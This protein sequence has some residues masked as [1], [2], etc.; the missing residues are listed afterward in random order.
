M[1]DQLSLRVKLL[2]GNG[3]IF[4]ILIVISMIVY[5]GINSLLNN[6]KWVDHTH[7]VLAKA[8]ATTAAA[9]D[10]ET[11]M[12]GFM[13]S[14][15]EEFLEPYKE[16]KQ[17]FYALTSELS[18]TV[19]DNPG[20]VAL[21]AEI[22]TLIT[23]WVNN[24]TEPNIAFRRTVG[25]AATME[26]VAELIRQAKGKAYFDSFR[27]KIAEFMSKEEVLLISRTDSFNSTS[28]FV[29]NVLLFGTL[30][31]I[32]IGI[33]FVS[34]LTKNIMKQLGGEPSFIAQIAKNVANGD[35]EICKSA[36]NSMQATGVLA[37]L[38]MMVT[39]LEKKSE[40]AN[41][42][43]Q[44]DLTIKVELA[45]DK[46]LLGISLQK[47][48]RNINDLLS[49][50]RSVST[51][52]SAGS[53]QLSAG[54]KQVAD[55]AN[56]QSTQ[57]ESISASLAQL[58]AQTNENAENA[59]K[60]QNLSLGAQGVAK[61]GTQNVGEMMTAMEDIGSSSQDIESFIKTI[62]EIAA[63]TNLLALNAAIEAA[64]AGEQGRG[65]AVVADEVRS[66]AARSA[67]TAQETSN[68]IAQSTEKT[69]NGIS[70]ATDTSE[71]LEDIFKRV[72]E[73]SDLITLIANAC[74]EQAKATEYIT[75]SVSGIDEVAHA[76]NESSKQTAETS[77]ELSSQAELLDEILQQFKIA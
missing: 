39:S 45:S 18:N 44:G 69:Q 48:V 43:A 27:S 57:L 54:S 21:L 37:E 77:K 23:E 11:G 71:S 26:D 19:N 16:G 24:I 2:S 50:I 46:D 7:N 62:D 67:Q 53:N 72:N 29:V 74:L 10:M 76:N 59:N 6:F 25:S 61:N 22:D 35:L 13:L 9:V 28:S 36:N 70:I 38:K 65:F 30:I 41:K 73:A 32:V 17:R 14:G 49:Q 75:K 3:V 52:I 64:R 12:R 58:N 55:G 33:S 51:S 1:F 31:I 40:A 63:Q 4:A 34:L 20:Q 42:I 66:L 56:E 15:K 47:M 5:F 8:A 68:L 60:A